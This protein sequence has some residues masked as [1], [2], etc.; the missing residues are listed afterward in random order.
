MDPILS[1]WGDRIRA[2]ARARMP[3]RIHGGNTKRF[4]GNDCDGEP[5]DTRAYQGIVDFQPSELVI[6]ARAGTSLAQLEQTLAEQRQVLAFEP[7][8]FGVGA[9]VGGCVAAGL[10]GPRRAAAGPVSG[11]IRDHVLGA[12]LLDGRGNLLHFGGTVIKNVAGYDVSR[13]LVGSLGVLGVIAEVSLKV[14]PAPIGETTLVFS[15]SQADALERLNEWGGKPLPISGSTWCDNVL[16]LRLSGARAAVDSACQLLGGQ[17]DSD[18]MFWTQLRE[19]RLAFF[20]GPSPIWRISVP[21]TA[22]ELALGGSTLLEWGGALRWVRSESAATQTRASVAAAG[23][24]ATLFRGGDRSAGAFTPLGAAELA[25]HRRLKAEF[26]P[27]DVFNRG[28]MYA[29]F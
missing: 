10:S 25:L 6:T 1:E 2:A 9:T 7:P 15:M 5:F 22:P 27:A 19:Q 13:A 11:A 16:R 4:Y 24:H 17:R 8:H 28:R 23:G 26:D 14:L 3:L 21:S 12:K 20:A 29:E 18:A